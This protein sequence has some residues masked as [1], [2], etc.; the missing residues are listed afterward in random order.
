MELTIIISIFDETSIEH[1]FS[2][3]QYYY[4]AVIF[5]ATFMNNIMKGSPQRRLMLLLCCWI[6]CNSV[7]RCNFIII[8]RSCLVT[9]DNYGVWPF[10]LTTNYLR[11]QDTTGTSLFG[12]NTGENW[13]KTG[14]GIMDQEL[15]NFSLT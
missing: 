6:K 5:Y 15:V 10:T 14:S 3:Y 11:R 13:S 9:E 7:I 4:F 2:L 12:G 8:I 1:L